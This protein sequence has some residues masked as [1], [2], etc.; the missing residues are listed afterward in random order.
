MTKTP[1]IVLENVSKSYDSNTFLSRKPKTYA[2][3]DVS[4][5]VNR[6]ETYGIV[7]ESG[8]GK[9][10]LA[11]LM[12]GILQP[13]SGSIKINEHDITVRGAFK[14]DMAGT[15]QFVFQ[16][17]YGSLNPKKTVGW[18]IEE[19]LHI[20]NIGRKAERKDKTLALMERVGL[21]NSYY[22]RYPHQLSGGQRQRV[23]IASAL[24]LNPEILVID[25]GV[26]ALD[27]SIQASILNL[28]NSLKTS[29]QLTLV[30]ITHD[31]NVVQY[32]CDRV[33]V[34]KDGVLKE[35]FDVETFHTDTHDDY[36]TH[37]FQS[38]LES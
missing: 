18:S 17:P 30:F 27:V 8:S 7:G 23:A 19:A 31:L 22:D 32:F 28:L 4:L 10:T 12:V 24:I 6:G 21:S 15:I 25:E 29:M 37:L 35:V 2:V 26:S 14:D 1:L 36:T 33:A 5:V 11:H 3:D 16:D 9:T 20:R 13:N 34:I 38:I